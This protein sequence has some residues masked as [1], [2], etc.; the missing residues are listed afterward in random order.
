MGAEKSKTSI[1]DTK[2]RRRKDAK[3]K[4]QLRM[5]ELCRISSTMPDTPI[6]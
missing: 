6:E 1:K 3:I 2:R 5:H 4:E